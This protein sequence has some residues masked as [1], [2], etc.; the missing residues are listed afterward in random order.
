[1]AFI[2]DDE[3]VPGQ[4]RSQ[5]R[6]AV[7]EAFNSPFW[8]FVLA[9]TSI[10]QEGLDF[11]LYCRNV[12]H[13]NLPTNPIDLEQ[14]EGRIN[15]RNSLSIR[16]A[17]RQDVDPSELRRVDAPLIVQAIDTIVRRGTRHAHEKHGLY[18]NWI[19]EGKGGTTNAVRRHLPIYGSSVDVDRYARLR[20]RLSLYR[21]A[22]GQANQDALLDELDRIGK[23]D[24]AVRLAPYML[25][26]APFRGGFAWASARQEAARR[27]RDPAGV[28]GWLSALVSD[29][30][31]KLREVRLSLG[32]HAAAACERL[33]AYLERA[34]AAVDAR[35]IHAA[36]ALVYFRNPYDDQFDVHRTIG[37][38][39][40]AKRLLSAAAQI[41]RTKRR[42]RTA[43]T[44]ERP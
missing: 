30:H 42:E 41:G 23:N 44:A 40:D 19:Y 32:P 37:L 9:T 16:L 22:F 36:A 31:E 25:N 33:I 18:P 21:L 13:W 7:R 39:D 4:R 28:S 10:G 3:S 43:T 26:L 1:V 14:R 38:K 17:M 6:A 8:P 35:T 27:L 34:P 20:K 24:L 15:R 12:V 2:E 5:R 11:H 29:C